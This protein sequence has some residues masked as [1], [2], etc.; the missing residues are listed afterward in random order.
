MN[1][2]AFRA[3]F[4]AQPWTATSI[5]EVPDVDRNIHEESAIIVASQQT[6][7][8]STLHSTQANSIV[9]NGFDQATNALAAARPTPAM[10]APTEM[11]EQKLIEDID[12]IIASERMLIQ[13]LWNRLHKRHGDNGGEGIVNGAEDKLSQAFDRTAVALA[14]ALQQL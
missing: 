13:S 6:S 12:L 3:Y 8:A 4:A 9:L 10:P 11:E 1:F 2:A 14:A 5:V 7:L